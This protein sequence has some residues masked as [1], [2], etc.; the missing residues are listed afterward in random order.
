MRESSPIFV[1]PS[2]GAR[3]PNR[4]R[5]AWRGGEE[6]DAGRPTGPPI[7]I[8]ASGK[9]GPGPVDVL[10]A[11]LATCVSI[12]VVEIMAKRRTPLALLEIEVVG[13]RVE[14]IP[15]RLEHVTLRFRA[16]GDGIERE[17][18]A[19]AIDLSLTKYCSVRDSLDPALPIEWELEMAAAQ[20]A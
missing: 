5:V 14:T 6:F 4:I 13:R 16:G 12:D 7:H 18:M 3:P 19:R 15:R 11:A 9:T 8:D 20:T 2:P 10:L 17:Q 1:Q